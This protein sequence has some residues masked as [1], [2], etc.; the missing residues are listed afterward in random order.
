MQ[1][2]TIEEIIDRL[3]EIIETAQDEN[4][5][6]GYFP[7]LYRLVTR[8]VKDRTEPGATYFHDNARMR[9]LVVI[10]ANR[11]LVAYDAFRRGEPYSTSWRV[12]FQAA[13]RNRYLVLQHLLLGINAHINLD[14]GLAVAELQQ[15]RR[16]TENEMESDFNKINEVLGALVNEVQG[17]LT[18]VNPLLRWVS[19]AAETVAHRFI[20]FSMKVAREFAWRTAEQFHAI[21]MEEWPKP[22][23]DKDTEVALLG[24]LVTHPSLGMR[25]LIFLIRLNEVRPTSQAIALMAGMQPSENQIQMRMDKLEEQAA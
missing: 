16:L 18:E 10:F 4:S 19:G 3:T 23:R 24:R 7:A 21:P 5:A 8:T 2:T 14:L 15:G 20:N 25:L 1:A 12:A 9:E 11:Y 17:R 6:L 13:K 22:E